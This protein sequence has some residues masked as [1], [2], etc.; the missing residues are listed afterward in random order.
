M[1][2]AIGYLAAGIAVMI[3]V[4][5]FVGWWTIPVLIICI[6]LVLIFNPM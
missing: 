6:I 4:G 2:Q 5:E 1:G 3:M